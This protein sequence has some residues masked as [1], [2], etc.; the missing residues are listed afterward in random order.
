M[1]KASLFLCLLFLLCAAFGPEAQAAS[2]SI[3]PS[4]IRVV[5][6]SPSSY[7]GT[8][9]LSNRSRQPVTLK[10][11][12]EDW[13]YSSDQNGVKVFFP[14]GTT[15]LSCA[16][17]I[18]FNPAELVIPGS[19]SALVNYTINVPPGVDGGRYA[20]MFFETMMP[21]EATQASAEGVGAGTSLK[22]RL[23]AIFCVEIKDTVKRS[24]D[25]GKFSVTKGKKEQLVIESEYKNTGNADII[26]SGSFHIMDKSGKMIGRSVF[27][28]GYTLPGDTAKIRGFWKDTLPKGRYDLV[29]SLDLGKAMEEIKGSKARGPVITKE[30]EIEIGE[31][32]QLVSVGEFK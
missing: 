5:L 14:A 7:S 6:P 32:G 25:L 20:V 8:I 12:M 15:A 19:G 2:Y 30:A 17:W 24:A 11:Y 23:G 16:S 3:D 22:L 10:V 1:R 28:D 13:L 27:N 31:N 26:T 18:S 4:K 21:G 9:K 29:V